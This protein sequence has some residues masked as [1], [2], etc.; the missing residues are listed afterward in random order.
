MARALIQEEVWGS[1]AKAP[2]IILPREAREAWDQAGAAA[3]ARDKA[4]AAAEARAVAQAA[5][6][7][8]AIGN[9]LII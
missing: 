6:E 2:G 9:V 4:E 3:E 1:A 5:A 8:G 7:A